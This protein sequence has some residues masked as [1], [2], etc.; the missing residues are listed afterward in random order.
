MSDDNICY[1]GSKVYTYR[2]CIF[3]C[4]GWLATFKSTTRESGR[5]VHM[6]GDI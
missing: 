6:G 2:E 1:R 5:E 4:G 3:V